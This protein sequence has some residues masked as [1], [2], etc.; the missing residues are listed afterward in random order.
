MHNLKRKITWKKFHKWVGLV[1]TVFLLLFC[2]SGI[3]LNHR[4]AVSGINVS[5]NILPPSYRISD[6]NNGIIRGTL[7]LSDST[8][9]A[10]GATGA[11]L[12]DRDGKNIIDFNSGFP[13]GVD[14]RN[15]RSMVRTNDGNIWCAAQY[16]LYK[17]QKGKWSKVTLPRNQERLSDITL[18]PDSSRIVVLTRSAVYVENEK[19]DLTRTFLPAPVDYSN[20]ISLFKT[21][22]NL[23]SGELFGLTGRIVVDIIAIIIIFLCISGILLFIFPHSLRRLARS[24]SVKAKER[25]KRE[26]RSLK[27]NFK[28]HNRI[29]YLTIIFTIIIAF[30]GMCLRPPLMIPF[31]MTKTSPIPGSS[32]DNDNPWHDKLRGIRWDSARRQWLLSTSEGFI[33]TDSTFSSSPV[34]LQ[35]DKTPPVSPM[36]ITVFEETEPGK[37]LVGSFSGLYKWDSEKGEVTDLSTGKPFKAGSASRFILSSPISGYSSD[38]NTSEPIVFDYT[39]GTGLLPEMPDLLRQQPMSLWNFALELHVGRCYTPFLGPLS[40]LFVFIS[41]AI[42]ILVLVSGLIMHNRL[43]KGNNI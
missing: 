32:L 4:E 17:L 43:K 39:Q 34:C 35:S 6:Y 33:R 27:W 31:V 2:F 5:R 24:S 20:Q 18:S 14:I 15:I 29:G 28:W 42:F 11:W 22:W 23:H 13:K 36:G 3:I 25:V 9:I 21:I 10:Y 37:W 38:Y 19:G 30:T 1:F 7:P 26:S 40:E 16:D 41:G 12:S 8:L